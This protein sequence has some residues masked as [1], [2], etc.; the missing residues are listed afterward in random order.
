MTC[1]KT[2]ICLIAIFLTACFSSLKAQS[3]VGAAG[4]TLIGNGY[5]VEYAIG[6]ISINTLTAPGN[7][8]FLTQG[9]LQPNLKVTNPACEIV[10]DEFQY[11]P[12]PTI[13]RIRLVG[14]NDWITHYIVYGADGKL[15]AS[16]Q[17]QNNFID[18]RRFPAG[19]YII[20]LLPGCN[21]Q[22]KTLKILKQNR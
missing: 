22:F 11:F 12:N 20:R 1:L 19:L 4:T 21:G 7:T 5:T 8:N 2:R 18:I 17:F 6:E 10:N 9:L 14:R 3:L 15:L 13:D 16:A